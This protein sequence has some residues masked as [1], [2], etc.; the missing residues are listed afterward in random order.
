MKRSFEKWIVIAMGFEYYEEN[1]MQDLIKFLD[2]YKSKLLSFEYMILSVDN[3]KA[4]YDDIEESD[5]VVNYN[6]DLDVIVYKNINNI[7][8]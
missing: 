1:Y 3:F 8:W 2:P 5:I 4:E 7:K 6:A